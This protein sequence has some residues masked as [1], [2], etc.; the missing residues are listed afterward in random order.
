[1]KKYISVIAMLVIVSVAVNSVAANV[2]TD[3]TE[4]EFDGLVGSNIV[5]AKLVFRAGG[6][7]SWE[8]SASDGTTITTADFN[9]GLNTG[10]SIIA[11]WDQ[12]VNSLFELT[13]TPPGGSPIIVG[14]LGSGAWFN[15]ILVSVEQH[16][17]F[18]SDLTLSNNDI[19]GEGFRDLTA[20]S[21]NTWDGLMISLDG[22][23]LNSQDSLMLS[24]ILTPTGLGAAD[25]Q[26]RG[27]IVFLQVPEPA[28][29]SLIS[30][31][32]LITLVIR[33]VVRFNPY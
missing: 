25:D 21:L 11:S 26:F 27:E 10:N 15:T 29:I 30:L 33:R 3:L 20:P 28:T 24:G 6:A 16:S 8:I 22:Y 23:G 5:A 9:W 17:G 7:N 4:T 18:I 12:D 31:A 13:V 32:G 14:T 19:D 1:M 2:V